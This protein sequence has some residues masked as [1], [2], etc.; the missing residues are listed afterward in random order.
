MEPLIINKIKYPPPFPISFNFFLKNQLE[1]KIKHLGKSYDPFLIWICSSTSMQLSH[2]K[3]GN[4]S[5][6]F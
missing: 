6:V 3:H 1:R 5:K 4:L 2:L